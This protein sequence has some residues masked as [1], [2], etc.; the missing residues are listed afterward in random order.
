MWMFFFYGPLIF[1][2]RGRVFFTTHLLVG[3]EPTSSA[4]VGPTL[5]ARFE[6]NGYLRTD[7]M[8]MLRREVLA[9]MILRAGSPERALEGASGRISKRHSPQPSKCPMTLIA[10]SQSILRTLSLKSGGNGR[11]MNHGGR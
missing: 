9:T 2:D 4:Q 7:G 3:L 10:I 5:L 1:R 11:C 6:R 8:R